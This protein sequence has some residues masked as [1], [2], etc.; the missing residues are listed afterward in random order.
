MPV[1][2]PGAPTTDANT[3]DNV[4]AKLTN[5]HEEE[6]KEPERAVTPAEREREKKKKQD[7]NT[8]VVKWFYWLVQSKCFSV[9][10]LNAP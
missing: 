5:V 1:F 2:S 3:L 9:V 6:N 8:T 7:M 10:Y 4:D